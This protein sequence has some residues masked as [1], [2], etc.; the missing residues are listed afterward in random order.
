MYQCDAQSLVG[1]ACKYKPSSIL[2]RTGHSHVLHRPVLVPCG[3]RPRTRYAHLAV[4]RRCIARDHEC[5]RGCQERGGGTFPP[6]CS[7]FLRSN[8]SLRCSLAPHNPMSIHLTISSQARARCRS[9]SGDT[10]AL[11]QQQL[12]AMLPSNCGAPRLV[13]AA[14]VA[15]SARANAFCPRSHRYFVSG[16]VA[17]AC[18]N[19]P[20]HGR[21]SFR[22]SLG[23]AISRSS[24][25]IAHQHHQS[26]RD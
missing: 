3:I 26:G 2:C 19:P 18:F 5:R 25:W 6:R 14:S 4:F 1:G 8:G 24:F 20:A 10:V 7:R 22:R 17:W 23:F 9:A 13:P 16:S 12:L 11:L 15:G 21:E